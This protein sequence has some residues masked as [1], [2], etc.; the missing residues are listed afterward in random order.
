M[1]KSPVLINNLT[2]NTN[3]ITPLA[4]SKTISNLW[5]TFKVGLWWKCN[6]CFIG[7][8]FP[9]CIR[10]QHSRHKGTFKSFKTHSAVFHGLAIWAFPVRLSKWD[11]VQTNFAKF[12]L[13][14][15]L[16]LA[17]T[18]LLPKIW[19]LKMFSIGILGRYFHLQKFLII[20]TLYSCRV[21][22]LG[23]TVGRWKIEL[24]CQKR[25]FF[26]LFFYSDS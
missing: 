4:C 16:L 26:S 5:K 2:E 25:G 21:G 22:D 10:I 1:Q 6:T 24:W 3:A 19:L 20:W 18:A 12:Q 7:E 9:T 14:F 11:G 23:I 13:S 15:Y 17:Y 8:S